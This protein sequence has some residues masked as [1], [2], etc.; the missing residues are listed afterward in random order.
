MN[1]ISL[2]GN[3][4]FMLLKYIIY[5][6]SGLLMEVFWTGIL[7]FISGNLALTGHTYIWMFFIYGLAILLEPIHDKIRSEN[8]VIRG[9]VWTALVYTIEFFSGLF[10]DLL[11]GFCPWDYSKSTNYTILGYIR[12]DYF[13]AWFIV[14]LFFEKYHDFLDR[15]TDK[16]LR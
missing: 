1:I 16:L 3:N 2:L 14:G 10:L 4:R 5:G 15:N 7:S 8:I 6:L 13:P 9:I 12:L 11:I